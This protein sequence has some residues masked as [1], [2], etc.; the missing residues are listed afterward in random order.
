ML[1]FR[2]LEPRSTADTFESL[3]V[4]VRDH[5]QREL[6]TI[7]TSVYASGQERRNEA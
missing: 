3:S 7:A 6:V 1:T 4:H 2:P 5:T